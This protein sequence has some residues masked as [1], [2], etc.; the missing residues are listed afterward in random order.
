MTSGL[1]II[2]EIALATRQSPILCGNNGISLGNIFNVFQIIQENR[3]CIGPLYHIFRQ[4][5]NAT[6]QREWDLTKI[7]IYTIS[8]KTLEKTNCDHKNTI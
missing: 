8:E 2:Q 7:N 6:L 1:W 4:E 5:K 3:C